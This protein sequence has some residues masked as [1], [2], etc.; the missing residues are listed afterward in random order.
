MRTTQV[1]EINPLA[2]DRAAIRRIALFLRRDGLIAYPTETFYGLGAAADSKKAVRRI[3]RLKRRESRK[4]LSV[5]VSDLDMLRDIIDGMPP[6]GLRLTREFWPG[7]LT[8]VLRAKPSFA[9]PVLGPSRS[10]G[11]RVPGPAWLR[12]LVREVAFPITATSANISG[13]NELSDPGDVIRFFSGKIDLVVDGGR[14]EGAAAS[15]VID[16]TAAEPTILREGA[17]PAEALRKC[18][19][20]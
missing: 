8:L 17:I 6:L 15:T 5:V 19:G 12:A 13:R 7:P 14:T 3:Y 11:V 4:P 9:S 1:I 2:V 10:L 16:L 20:P 18:L